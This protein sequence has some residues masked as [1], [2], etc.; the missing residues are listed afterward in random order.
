MKFF[1]S[2]KWT[3]DRIGRVAILLAVPGCLLIAT[4][5]LHMT[6]LRINFSSSE[7]I[8]IYQ[9]RPFGKI[10]DLRHSDLVVFCP[11]ITHERFPFVAKGHCPTGIAPLLKHV[12]GLPGDTVTETDEGVA[13][14]GKAIAFS[15]PKSYSMAYALPLPRWRGA[16]T[17]ARNE[18]WVYGAGDPGN[19]FDSRYF[20]PVRS[21]SILS[22]ANGHGTHQNGNHRFGVPSKPCSRGKEGVA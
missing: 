1:A 15:K 16:H 13:I 3:P 5:A 10:G 18:I 8:G 12:A 9:T 7:P 11:D 14:N 2:P 17:L 4:G 22:I 20:G 6:G 21:D 19:S